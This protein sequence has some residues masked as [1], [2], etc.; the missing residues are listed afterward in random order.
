MM[1]KK[2]KMKYCGCGIYITYHRPQVYHIIPQHFRGRYCIKFIKRQYERKRSYILES[3]YMKYEKRS[4][5]NIK[6]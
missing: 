3:I 4:S 1:F 6:I 2:T 5:L